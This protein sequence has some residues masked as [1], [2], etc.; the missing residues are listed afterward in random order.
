MLF[1]NIFDAEV[2]NDECKANGAGD[3]LP[4]AWCVIDFVVAMFGKALF[5]EFVG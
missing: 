4:Q 1:T 2:I 5:E 3:M